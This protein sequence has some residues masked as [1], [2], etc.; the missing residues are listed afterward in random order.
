MYLFLLVPDILHLL[1]IS[2]KNLSFIK[3]WGNLIKTYELC[4]SAG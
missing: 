4:S 3:K 2:K 1:E